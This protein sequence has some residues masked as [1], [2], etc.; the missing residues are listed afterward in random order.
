MTDQDQDL[1][2]VGEGIDVTERTFSCPDCGSDLETDFGVEAPWYGVECPEC[3]YED[4][5]V[6]G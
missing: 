5:W 3:G 1:I 2:G 6:A 4:T